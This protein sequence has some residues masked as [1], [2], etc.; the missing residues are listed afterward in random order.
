MKRIACLLL[1]V[2]LLIGLSTTVALSESVPVSASYDEA[3]KM[4]TVST[5]ANGWFTIQVDGEETQQYLKESKKSVTFKI[6]LAD[7]THSI[8]L[9]DE[10]TWNTG[11]ASVKVGST[12]P[13]PTDP[14]AKPTDPPVTPTDPPV[15]PTEPPVTPTEPPVTPTEAPTAAPVGPVKIDSASYYNGVITFT[16]SGVTGRSE[17][18]V[19]GTAT[20]RSV[21]APGT[22][23]VS[24]RLG[25]G[26]HYI[27]I[28]YSDN[29]ERDSKTFDVVIK[30]PTVSAS[31]TKVGTLTFT[32]NDLNGNS[33]IW[34]DGIATGYS[35][36]TNGT[37]T[38]PVELTEGSHRIVILDTENNVRAEDNFVVSHIE[39]IDPAVPATCTETGLSEGIHC[40]ICGL[41]IKAQEVVPAA[42]HV[43]GEWVELKAATCT[44]KGSKE[45]H[46]SVCNAV[47][48]TED[49]PALGHNYQ[50]ADSSSRY[51][52]YKCTRCGDS[53]TEYN[54]K[55]VK[56]GYG[57]IVNDANRK[58][59]D[60]TSQGD[61]KNLKIVADLNTADTTEVGLYLDDTVISDMKKDG[62]TTVTF[63]NGD[64][65][66]EIDLSKAKSAKFDSEQTIWCYVFATDPAQ[67]TLVKVEGQISG[68]EYIE[69]TSFEGVKLVKGREKIDITAN[70]IY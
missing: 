17:I 55:A 56:N 37:H 67:N 21:S 12:A 63:Y 62:F 19:D 25:A 20:G 49:I 13:T 7:G 70:G 43:D 46:C 45:L 38:I 6:D 34:L 40:A 42:G 2:L 1:A 30:N 52:V 26:S 60:Y 22:Y 28:Y 32:V 66:I 53:F 65:V 3:T 31:Y 47:I 14:P 4:L 16:V 61:G 18:W 39:V 35:V 58:P 24:F 33:E 36:S 54:T 68:D 50:V 69:A 64:A 29:N 8:R 44:V 59:V 48:R 57:N 23:T 51:V 9:L 10:S 41:V 11:T 5:T 27:T 15:T